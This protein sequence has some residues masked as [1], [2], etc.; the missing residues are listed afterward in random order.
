MLTSSHRWMV[1]AATMLLSAL[2]FPASARAECVETGALD[3]LASARGSRFLLL[4]YDSLQL[5]LDRD[6]SEH[7]EAIAEFSPQA[8]SGHVFAAFGGDARTL[9]G[10]DVCTDRGQAPGDLE[11]LRGGLTAGYIGRSGWSVRLSWVIGQD[12]IDYGVMRTP[13]AQQGSWSFSQQLLAVELRP[14]PQL[15]F[16]VSSLGRESESITPTP[17]GEMLTHGTTAP[18]VGGATMVSARTA[19]LGGGAAVLWTPG[20]LQTLS[21]GFSEVPIVDGLTSTLGVGYLVDERQATSVVGLRWAHGRTLASNPLGKPLPAG[22]SVG[23][24][25]TGWALSAEVGQEYRPVGVRDG[26][27]RLDGALQVRTAQQGI[28]MVIDWG[29]YVE[30]TLAGSRFFSES[31]GRS[32]TPG[33]GGGIQGLQGFRFG[34]VV[35]DLYAGVNRPETLALIPQA[36][37]RPEVRGQMLWRLGW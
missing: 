31:T 7:A 27:V 36:V 11:Q 29:A 21:L 9:G 22:E 1:A 18:A 8:P 10:Y 20:G 35:F 25:S 23:R 19:W 15:A 6:V 2:A 5:N 26:R 30:T 37:A 32:T 12:S 16:T 34:S 14:T 4:D 3:A 13:H 17:D 28:S 33:I 24:V